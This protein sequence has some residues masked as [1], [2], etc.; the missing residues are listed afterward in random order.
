MWPGSNIP[1]KSVEPNYVIPYVRGPTA[2]DKMDIVLNW[3]DLPLAERPQSISV[4]IPQ[5]DQ[6]GHG[7]G[8]DGKQVLLIHNQR[9]SLITC[10]Y[11]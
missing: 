2:I 1:I 6:K 5:V 11:S 7:G 4:Y 10:F 3:L 9:V 8:P